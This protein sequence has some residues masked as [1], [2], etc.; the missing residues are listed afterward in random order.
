MPVIIQQEWYTE[1]QIRENRNVLFLFGDNKTRQ[2]R[3]GQAKVC[4]DEPNCIG[5]ITKALAEHGDERCYL[6][7]EYLMMNIL[8]IARDFGKVIHHLKKGGTVIFPADGIGTGLAE[9]P[10]RAPQTYE[11]LKCMWDYAIWIGE[12]YPE[13]TAETI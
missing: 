5:V 12:Q 11:F 2:G 10:Q 3:G 8:E 4:R 13:K 9:L 6:S 1:K 7:D